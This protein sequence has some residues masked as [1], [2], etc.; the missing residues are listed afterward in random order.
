[1]QTTKYTK[2][3]QLIERIS[4]LRSVI[5]PVGAD[6]SCFVY[7]VYFV[8]STVFSCLLAGCSPEASDRSNLHTQFFEQVQIIGPLATAP[9][10]LNKP[11]PAALA[12]ADNR[13]TA[14]HSPR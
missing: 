2:T 5:T 13:S 1:M 9:A 14:A 3:E 12:T 7:L 6:P 8:V 10:Q 4:F 11:R